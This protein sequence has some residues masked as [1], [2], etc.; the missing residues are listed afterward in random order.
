MRYLL[1]ILSLLTV[2]S[3]INCESVKPVYE[4]KH[5]DNAELNE[6]LQKINKK[7]PDI[8]RLYEL[9]ERSVRGWPLTVIEISDKP[10]RHEFRKYNLTEVRLKFSLNDLKK[11][12]K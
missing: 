5:H 11:S 7:C 4:F 9:R 12:I 8:T 3:I 6:V 2:V 10:G 1:N